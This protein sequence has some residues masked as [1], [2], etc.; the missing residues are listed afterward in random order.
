MEPIR[1]RR[2]CSCWNDH[3]RRHIWFDGLRFHI[4]IS[5]LNLWWFVLSIYSNDFGHSPR[6]LLQETIRRSCCLFRWTSLAQLF[7]VDLICRCSSVVHFDDCSHVSETNSN[8]LCRHARGSHSRLGFGQ[9]S[10]AIVLHLSSEINGQSIGHHHAHALLRIVGENFHFDPRNRRSNSHLDLYHKQCRQFH[11]DPSA[12]IL[13]VSSHSIERT[14]SK[15]TPITINS[16]SSVPFFFLI[17]V[18]LISR[19]KEKLNFRRI[20]IQQNIDTDLGRLSNKTFS[21]SS[22]HWLELIVSLLFSHILH[23]RHDKT[24]IQQM[25]LSLAWL[26]RRPSS[27]WV[28][29]SVDIFSSWLEEGIADGT[30]RA[31]AENRTN[32]Q[33][34][35]TKKRRTLTFK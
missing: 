26:E 15:K 22:N 8:A 24:N 35:R 33:L 19:T 27:L 23:I 17:F 13:L 16:S 18:F 28:R 25:F 5:S 4:W 7:S 30:T 3:A 1:R 12:W 6:S 34:E 32:F 10:L 29:R 21:S 11:L 14:N 20:E 9:S 2:Q 31:R